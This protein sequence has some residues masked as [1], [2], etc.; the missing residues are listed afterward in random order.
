MKEDW[1]SILIH[2]SNTDTID[3]VLDLYKTD[4][5]K[6]RV[7][8]DSE[9]R[10]GSITTTYLHDK[11]DSEDFS[12]VTYLKSYGFNK[13]GSIYH[14]EK[15]ECSIIYTKG[16]CWYSTSKGVILFVPCNQNH[17]NSKEVRDIM[18]ERFPWLRMFFENMFEFNTLSFNT[19]KKNKLFS[20]KKALSF[21]VG[22][23]YPTSKILVSGHYRDI[24]FYKRFKDYV[25]NITSL[26]SKP[27]EDLNYVRLLSDTAE[28]FKSLGKKVNI[29]WSPRRLKEEHDKA[30]KE[31][32][33]IL[34]DV[35]PN[36]PLNN[37]KV[38]EKFSDVTGIEL[39]RDTKS[40]VIEG[41]LQQ[42]CVASY[43]YHVNLGR[44]GIFKFK[45]NTLE[46]SIVNKDNK[47]VLNVSQLRGFRNKNAGEFL[48][49]EIVFNIERFLEENPDLDYSYNRITTDNYG[50][51]EI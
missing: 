26:P 45:G 2:K 17:T 35:L 34:Y 44:S 29:S 22:T 41:K 46:L 8:F 31:Y 10:D 37:H 51:L 5:V 27:Y 3:L 47:P 38:F 23:N 24:N 19:I 32:T 7:L 48:H 4:K 39:I 42:H 21:V 18:I 15:R 1:E 20:H 6:A 36:K 30:S 11:K 43:Q 25:I 12:I 28:M 49:E 14:R 33:N 16:K 40:L 9:A 50:L 13:N